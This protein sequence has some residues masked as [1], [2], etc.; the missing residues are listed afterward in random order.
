MLGLPE[1]GCFPLI[2]LI[3]GY[4]S[5]VPERMKGRLAGAGVVH[6]GRYTPL[7]T[8]GLDEMIAAYDDP[9]LN[10]GMTQAF[11][12]KGYAHYLEWFF[13]DWRGGFPI[14]TGDEVAERLK[15]SGF[16]Q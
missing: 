3:L 8:N 10:L 6:R 11:A 1:R 12:S 7:D 16:L 14:K 5:S 15:K 2:T 4:A 13:K 9:D